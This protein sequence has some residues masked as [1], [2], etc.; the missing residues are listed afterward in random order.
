MRVAR[1]LMAGLGGALIGILPSAILGVALGATCA[2]LTAR[3]ALDRAQVA[4]FGEVT[5]VRS[6]DLRTGGEIDFKV[7][8]AFKGTDAGRTMTVAIAA[9][10]AG[11]VGYWIVEPGTWHTLYLRGRAEWPAWPADA[12][13]ATLYTSFCFGSHEGPPTREEHLLFGV[14]VGELRVPGRHETGIA[15]LPPLDPRDLTPLDDRLARAWSDAR[16]L[17][18]QNPDVLGPPWVDRVAGQLVVSLVDGRGHDVVRSWITAG[19]AREGNK[20]APPLA[21]PQVP[22]RIRDV[23]RSIADL[24]RIQDELTRPEPAGY[25]G[26]SRIWAVWIDEQLDRVA[27]ETD[28]LNPDLLAAIA[29]TYGTEAVAVRVDARAGPFP[30]AA[31]S[32][33]DPTPAMLAP[34]AALAGIAALIAGLLL[35]RRR[36]SVR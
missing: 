10:G 22:V 2:Q 13:K 28:R 29:R 8:R 20:P 3:Q 23:Q 6:A 27:F 17:A 34:A 31:G 1:V 36:R 12:P 4:V 16:E 24:R 35:A 32:W 19:A 11:T 15:V 21:A 30:Q 33:T 9:D 25:R 7:A 18:D 5:A 14:P 26:E